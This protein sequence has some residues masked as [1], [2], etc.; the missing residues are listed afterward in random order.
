MSSR[1]S[2]SRTFWRLIYE[3]LARNITD[4]F[5]A[6]PLNRLGQRLRVICIR[7][8]VQQCGKGLKIGPNVTL[9]WENVIGDNVTINANCKLQGCRIDDYALI[10]PECYCVIRNHEYRAPD[11]PIVNQGYTTEC[12]PHIGRDVWIGAR[13]LLLPGITLGEGSIIAAGAVVNSDTEPYSI[14]GGV[15]AKRIGYRGKE[16][17]DAT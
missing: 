4:D 12:P 16:T 9:S 11:I 14:V 17:A 5:W 13:V 3:I 1:I 2:L 10:A 6:Y 15:P 8:F 7:G